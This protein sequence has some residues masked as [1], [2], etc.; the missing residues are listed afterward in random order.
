MLLT[1]KGGALFRQDFKKKHGPW[2][3][4]IDIEVTPIKVIIIEFSFVL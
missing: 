1:Q 2:N 4:W 3:C